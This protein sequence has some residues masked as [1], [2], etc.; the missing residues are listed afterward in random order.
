MGDEKR[1]ASGD[2]AAMRLLKGRGYADRV[3]HIGKDARFPTGSRTKASRHGHSD[4]QCGRPGI[5]MS[6]QKIQPRETD[7]AHVDSLGFTL[8]RLNH[9]PESVRGT[10]EAHRDHRS[11]PRSM[12]MSLRAGHLDRPTLQGLQSCGDQAVRIDVAPA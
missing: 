11:V 5:L 10:P 3:G 9:I 8:N 4:L 1:V 6:S 7:A 2:G 12:S